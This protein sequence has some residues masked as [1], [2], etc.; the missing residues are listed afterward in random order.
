[1]GG[2]GHRTRLPN[3]YHSPDPLLKLG[4]VKLESQVTEDE[5]AWVNRVRELA[6]TAHHRPKEPWGRRS[7]RWDGCE[8]SILIRFQPPG[9]IGLKL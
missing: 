1:M 7:R 9:L 8:A 2:S 3:A 6:H 4:G 5:H